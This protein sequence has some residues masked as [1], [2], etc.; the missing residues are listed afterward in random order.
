MFQKTLIQFA[1]LRLLLAPTV[2]VSQRLHRAF[3]RSI[4]TVTSQCC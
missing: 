2:K 1:S 4:V 3:R